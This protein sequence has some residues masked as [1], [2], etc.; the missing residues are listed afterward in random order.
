MYLRCEQT[1]SSP[2]LLENRLPSGYIVRGFLPVSMQ[3]S[4]F[5]DE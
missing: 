3:K 2:A 1:A 5:R 4:F